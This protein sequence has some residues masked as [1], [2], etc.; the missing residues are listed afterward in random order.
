MDRIL[1]PFLRDARS[2][3]FGIPH[4]NQH[5]RTAYIV[6]G[7]FEGQENQ[8]PRQ[9]GW[10]FS[11]LAWQKV[12][13]TLATIYQSLVEDEDFRQLSELQRIAMIH[14]LLALGSDERAGESLEDVYEEEQDKSNRVTLATGHAF[15]GKQARVVYVTALRDLSPPKP[16]PHEEARCWFYVVIT[17]AQ[18]KLILSAAEQARNYQQQFQPTR[19]N[20]LLAEFTQIVLAWKQSRKAPA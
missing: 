19:D 15:K 17:R 8:L 5:L 4:L 10:Q 13:R 2:G 6:H 20:P 11:E 14:G 1:L 18:D 3:Q 12:T 9:F 7:L 16:D